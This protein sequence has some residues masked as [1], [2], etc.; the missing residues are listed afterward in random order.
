MPIHLTFDPAGRLLVGSL[1]AAAFSV[2]AWRAGALTRSGA[3]AAAAIGA[4]ATSAGWDWAALLIGYFVATS[5]LSRFGAARKAAR[6]QGIVAKGGTRDWRQVAANGGTYAAG[7]A[8]WAFAGPDATFGALAI[9]ALAAATADSWGTEVGTL[10]R[11][12]PRSLLTLQRVPAGTSGGVTLGGTVAT[13]AGAAFIAGLA[14]ALGWDARLVRAAMIGG[15]A[16]ALVDS[17]LGAV[18]Q[19]RRWCPRCHLATERVRHDCGTAT[20]AAGGLPWLDNDVV[21]LACAVT[22][23]LMA[24]AFTR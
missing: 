6:T 10:S 18:L 16:G 22:G 14:A 9:G 24:V 3:L 13:I 7:A 17:A 12:E 20:E 2:V 21:N 8:A 5:A 15:V 19:A 4:V 1:L 23:G 11:G